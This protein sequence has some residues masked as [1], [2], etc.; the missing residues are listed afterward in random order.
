VAASPEKIL[1]LLRLLAQNDEPIYTSEELD[2]MAFDLS[3]HKNRFTEARILAQQVVEVIVETKETGFSLAPNAHALL[4]KREPTQYD[5][6]HYLFW[7]TW[8]PETTNQHQARSWWYHTLCEQLWSMGQVKLDRATRQELTQALNN[9]AEDDFQAVPGFSTESLSL[10]IQTLDGALKWLEHL[11]P[12]V[13]E[14]ETFS[15]RAACSGELFL[16]ALS[17][18][19]E[20]SSAEVGMD[21][22]LTPQRRE[23]ICHLCLLEP[24]RFDTMLDWVLPMFPQFLSQ[25]TR[26]GSYG[27]FVRLQR[28]VTV[29]TLM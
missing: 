10:S 7:T 12:P 3:D 27:R 23:E 11:K 16:L 24:V 13:I 9:Q 29:E 17:R 5:L 21:L 19:Y 28:L 4:K 14:D 25:G 8:Q 6:L 15:R 1:I 22:L 20:R 26:A 2:R 18:S